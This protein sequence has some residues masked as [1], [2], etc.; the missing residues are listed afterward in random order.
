MELLVLGCQAGMPADGWPSS[1]YLVTTPTSRVLLDCG[2][3][4]A[5]AL[6][7]HGSAGSLDAIVISHL[8]PDHCVDLCGLYVTRRYRP[9]GADQ[10]GGKR[11]RPGEQPFV[12]WPHPIREWR[13]R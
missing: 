2:P 9:G 13:T 6:S 3:G 8:H 4:V 11:E 7:S 12:R 1:G 10:H 5:T